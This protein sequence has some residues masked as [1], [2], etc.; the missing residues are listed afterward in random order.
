MKVVAVPALIAGLLAFAA[1]LPAFSQSSHAGHGAAARSTA[2]ETP[3]VKAFKA[4]NDRM[5]RDM[6]I[7]FTGDVDVDFVRAMI[8]HHEG[9]VAMAKILLENGGKDPETRKLAEEVV[10]TQQKEI[11]EMKAWLAKRGR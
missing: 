6:A 5:H 9:A 3:A 7:D 11:A 10:R 4:A 2:P 1:P 8:P